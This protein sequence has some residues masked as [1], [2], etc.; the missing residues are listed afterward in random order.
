MTAALPWIAPLFA[1]C[2]RPATTIEVFV[3]SDIPRSE[4]MLLRVA[5]VRAD[6]APRWQSLG[7]FGP[8]VPSRLPGSFTI[9]STREDETTVRLLIEA[10]IAPPRQRVLRREIVL[11]FQHGLSTSTRV[12]LSA[13]C[14]DRRIGC[15]SPGECTVS[16][17]CAER[18]LT[19]G[20]DGTC[21]APEARAP[22][23]DAGID[24]SADGASPATD[25]ATA[26]DAVAPACVEG[27]SR[28]VGAE[29]QRCSAGAF[30]T[31]TS[32]A[33]AALCAS[34]GCNAPACNPGQ[35]RCYGRD[36]ER[37]NGSRTGWDRVER[38]A[39]NVL[40][41]PNSC[42]APTCN[43]GQWRC[44][45]ASRETCNGDRNGWARVEQCATSALCTPGGCAPPACAA[46][47]YRCDGEALQSC[48]PD[49]TGW[50]TIRVCSG[51][52]R[53]APT[54]PGCYDGCA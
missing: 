54:P 13:R 28:C 37:C 24:G 25:A 53:C 43:T 31:V 46:G 27:A 49:R 40:C 3:D 20:D 8:N 36:R 21:V 26:M 18:Q 38:C 10:D 22:S 45:G 34:A 32:C 16:L 50:D 9:V 47:E 42:V 44:N 17:L 39:N 4:T 2:A 33:S 14:S 1:A 5:A 29:L 12:F 15:I 30:A 19:C 48:R 52:D 51:C 35:L 23:T 11:T 7:T 6:G 41:T